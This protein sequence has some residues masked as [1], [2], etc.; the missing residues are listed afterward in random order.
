MESTPTTSMLG[1][2]GSWVLAWFRKSNMFSS[3]RCNTACKNKNNSYSQIEN[4]YINISKI[5]IYKR[6]YSPI[7]TQQIFSKIFTLDICKVWWVFCEFR[8]VLHHISNHLKRML[9]SISKWTILVQPSQCQAKGFHMIITE[10][11]WIQRNWKKMPKS[12]WKLGNFQVESR[13]LP[14]VPGGLTAPLVV[15]S[16]IIGKLYD[17]LRWFFQ[18]MIRFNIHQVH[19]E[20]V[21]EQPALFPW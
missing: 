11:A 10:S 13:R 9:H 16:G 1:F 3:S 20:G 18:R 4:K 15:N 19:L 21:F 7:K 8:D 14:E 5:Y 2:K 17:S 12:A 6:S